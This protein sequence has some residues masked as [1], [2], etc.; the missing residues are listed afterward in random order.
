MWSR[1]SGP[2]QQTITEEGQW[3]PGL[4]EAKEARLVE[5]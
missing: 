1:T 4:Q 3:G 2:C 5:L